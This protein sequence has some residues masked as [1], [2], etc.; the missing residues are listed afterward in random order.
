[1]LGFMALGPT[2]LA[3][4]IGAKYKGVNK[5]PMAPGRETAVWNKIQELAVRFQQADRIVL[6]VPM[7]NFA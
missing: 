1:M 7:W 5:E 4:A 2:I 6:G 3:E